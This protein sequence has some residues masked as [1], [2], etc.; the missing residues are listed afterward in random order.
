MYCLCVCMYVCLMDVWVT[1]ENMR[2]VSSCYGEKCIMV[3]NDDDDDDDG[4][5]KAIGMWFLIMVSKTYS[6]F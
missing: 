4:E 6:G 2:L 3:S 5:K 1:M